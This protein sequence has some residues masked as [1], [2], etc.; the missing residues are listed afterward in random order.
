[1]TEH[2]A[3]ELVNRFY[4]TFLGGDIDTVL[5]LLA[6]DF[7]LVYSGPPVIPAAGTWKGH[8]GFRKWAEASLG[9]HLPPESF[10]FDEQ[11]E[12]GD[13]VA[14][15]GHVNLRV[16]TTGKTCETDFLHLWTVRDG[17]L[18]SF[19]DFFDTFA[20]AQAYMP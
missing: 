6:S 4:E 3:G 19:I 10:N 18:A 13:K 16:K 15:R 1:M 2:G 14:I 20:L 11:I 9:G 8:D 5:E 17:K 12:H 7:E